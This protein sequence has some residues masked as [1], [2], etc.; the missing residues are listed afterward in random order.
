MRISQVAVAGVMAMHIAPL[1]AAGIKSNPPWIEKL[2][3]NFDLATLNESELAARRLTLKPIGSLDLRDGKLVATDPLVQPER[4]PFTRQVPPGVY[5]ANAVVSD[6]EK[7]IVAEVIRFAPETPVA[8]ELA[9]V[10]GQD[11]STLKDEH[12]F[13]IPVDAGVAAFATANF[14]EAVAERETAERA[15]AR[16]SNYYDDVLAYEMPGTGLDIVLHRP[17]AA[18]PEAAAAIVSSG[19]GDGFYPVFF[20]LNAAGEAVVAI[21]D[22]QVIEHADGRTKEGNRKAA[23]LAALTPDE[24][25][26]SDAAFA[27]INNSDTVGLGKLLDEKKVTPDTYVPVEQA[28]LLYVAIRLDKPSAVRLFLDHGARDTVPECVIFQEPGKTYSGYAHWLE[29]EGRRKRE[30]WETP[31]APRSADL[32]T[33]MD[34]LAKRP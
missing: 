9:V 24:R 19:W 14:S 3:S 25:T 7:R 13:G 5:Q 34:E 2:S 26:A 12:Y 30:S 11:I 21:I 32:M 23:A 31:F 18:R 15:R 6:D 29:Q 10:P 16:Y 8:W 28:S 27:A 17:V 33:L 20:G 4:P 1:Q 22:F